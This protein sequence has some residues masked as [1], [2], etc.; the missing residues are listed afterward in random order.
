MPTGPARG[1]DAMVID[2]YGPLEDA[3]PRFPQLAWESALVREVIIRDHSSKPKNTQCTLEFLTIDPFLNPYIEEDE[4]DPYVTETT[5][6]NIHTKLD[7]IEKL[8]QRLIE[9]TTTTKR[10]PDI[11]SILGK[12]HRIKSMLLEEKAKQT[13][14]TT[15]QQFLQLTALVEEKSRH[16]E[17]SIN[18][19]ASS[20]S[21]R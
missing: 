8:L 7:D 16:L 18:E 15:T 5:D 14:E 19:V 20:Q 10:S 17:E 4:A 9:D 12:L 1:F 21:T 2:H 3:I 11:V 13:E 6:A